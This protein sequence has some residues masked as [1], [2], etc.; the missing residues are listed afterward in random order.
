MADTSARLLMYDDRMI[1]NML[2]L[3]AE[4]ALQGSEY[5]LEAWKILSAPVR[6]DRRPTLDEIGRAEQLLELAEDDL[7]GPS[8]TVDLTREEEEAF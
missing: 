4:T 2:L 6:E 3:A 5:G 8:L 7:E 1:L